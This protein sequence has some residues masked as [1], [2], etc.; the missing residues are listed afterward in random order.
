M[1][2]YTD[3]DIVARGLLEH[4]VPFIQKPFMP[5]DIAAHLRKAL[6]GKAGTESGV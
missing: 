5:D 4:D 6:D 3:T 1:S 2:G